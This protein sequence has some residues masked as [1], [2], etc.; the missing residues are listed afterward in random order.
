MN[1]N[2]T[3]GQFLLRTLDLPSS[4]LTPDP[5]VSEDDFTIEHRGGP[6]NEAI[7]AAIVSFYRLKGIRVEMD[8][9]L[10][11]EIHDPATTADK[12]KTIVVSNGFRAGMIHCTI[13]EF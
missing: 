1:T 6:T 13:Q 3:L 7:E 11:G 12:I 5:S 8:R 4:R 2:E 10:C 9:Y